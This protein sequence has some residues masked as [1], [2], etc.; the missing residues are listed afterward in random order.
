MTDWLHFN[1]FINHVLLISQIIIN[2]SIIY[3]ILAVI[4][5]NTFFFTFASNIFENRQ[6][7]VNMN[8]Y[9]DKILI[10]MIKLTIFCLFASY[11]HSNFIIKGFYLWINFCYFCACFC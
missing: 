6:N 5:I 7:I 3:K 9:E 11:S 2:K 1:T 8:L 10:L 4:R